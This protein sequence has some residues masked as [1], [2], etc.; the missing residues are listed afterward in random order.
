MRD[1]IDEILEMDDYEYS[2][3][4]DREVVLDVDDRKPVTYFAPWRYICQ[5]NV[6]GVGHGTGTLIGPKTVLTAAH[7]AWDVKTKTS[8]P[9][10]NVLQG[11]NGP[12]QLQQSEVEKVVFPSGLID[13]VK[14]WDYNND[15]SK[16]HLDYA[17]LHLKDRIGVK[18][19]YWSFAHKIWKDDPIGTSMW[20][21]AYALSKINVNVAGYPGDKGNNFAYWD[22]DKVIRND[23]KILFYQNDTAAGQSGAPVFYRKGTRRRVLIGIHSGGGGA[24]KNRAVFLNKSVQAFIQKY[25]K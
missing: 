11:K 2:A 23:G 12:D 15:K 3:L 19:G 16:W 24:G 22:F 17:I 21:S 7:V 25:T 8:H 9:R 6:I 20:S 14:G 1:L 10:I 13:P 4:E 5:I 18:Y